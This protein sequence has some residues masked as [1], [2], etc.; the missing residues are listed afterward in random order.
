MFKGTQEDRFVDE[1]SWEESSTIITG[2]IKL[3]FLV[4]DR[5]FGPYSFKGGIL[6]PAENFV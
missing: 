6:A 4:I 3:R 1:I 2:G 5:I